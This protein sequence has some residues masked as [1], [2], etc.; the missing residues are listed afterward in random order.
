[1]HASS[2][3][4]QE[5]QLFK[6]NISFVCQETFHANLYLQTNNMKCVTFVSSMSVQTV[7]LIFA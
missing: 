3:F 5:I 4:G 6:K 7:P 1:M 2:Q